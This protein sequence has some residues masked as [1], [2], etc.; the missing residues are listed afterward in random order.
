[1]IREA[2]PRAKLIANFA[3]VVY[4][5]HKCQP[6][7]NGRRAR[8]KKLA[9]TNKWRSENTAALFSSYFNN[10]LMSKMDILKL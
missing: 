5:T 9:K 4:K 2:K 6:E 10:N 8:L 7:R 3:N 1:V